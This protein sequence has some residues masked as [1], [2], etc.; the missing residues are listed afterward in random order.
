[1]TS[2]VVRPVRNLDFF[3]SGFGTVARHHYR[4]SL[5][6]FLSGTEFG[7]CKGRVSGRCWPK[8]EHLNDKW[9]QNTY[10]SSRLCRSSR[11]V[12]FRAE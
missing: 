3:L 6:A 1:M 8:G 7:A 9:E 11:Q 10:A 4:E 12:R 2:A 5:P